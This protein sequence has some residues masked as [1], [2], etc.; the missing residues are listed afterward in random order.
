VRVEVHD[1]Q[2]PVLASDRAQHGQGDRVVTADREG[3]GPG[4]E[5]RRDLVLY[6]VAREGRGEGGDGDVAAVDCA[7]RAEHI[8]LVGRMER[9]DEGADPAHLVRSEPRARAVRRR[10]VEGDADDDGVEAGVRRSGLHVRHWQPE[11]GRDALAD[12]RE[13]G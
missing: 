5:D 3:R 2:G 8:D 1:R 7:K 13:S 6:D 11:E 10:H 9:L 12:V 4:G